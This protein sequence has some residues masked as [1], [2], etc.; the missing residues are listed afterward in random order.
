MARYKGTF[1]NPANYE[2]LIAAPFDARELVDTKADLRAASTWQQKNGD[3]WLYEGME[4][5][6]KDEHSIYILNNPVS[7]FLE[8]SWSKIA[9][10][11]DIEELKEII[12][13]VPEGK[14]I[15]DLINA[16]EGGTGGSYDDTELVNRI[17]ELDKDYGALKSLIG[18]TSV[19]EQITAAIDALAPIAK[20]GDIND[21][22]QKP[23]EYVVL[24]CGNSN[25]LQ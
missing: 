17:E 5:K 20:S 12:G 9:N 18:E 3:L 10:Y 13:A 22:T 15:I 2:P 14:T 8:E 24:S 6:V 11:S 4:V 7:Y 23:N 16:I 19:A 1:Q 25:E 21:L